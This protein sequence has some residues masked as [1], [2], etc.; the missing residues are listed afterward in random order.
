[1]VVILSLM[2][3]FAIHAQETK[4]AQKSESESQI[5][6]NAQATLLP[7]S[8][9]GLQT[10]SD[11]KEFQKDNLRELAPEME[12]IFREYRVISA[13]SRDYGSVK[14]EVFQTQNQFAAFGL[15]SFVAGATKNQPGMQPFGPESARVTSGIVFWKG[16]VFVRLRDTTL[17]S[18]SESFGPRRSWPSGEKL[19]RAISESIVTPNASVKYPPLLE[20]LPTASKI[21][22]TEQYFLGPE[23]LNADIKHGR[24]MFDFIGE[25]EAVTADYQQSGASVAQGNPTPDQAVADSQR[26]PNS[27]T[28]PDNLPLTLVIVECHTPEFATDELARVTGSVSSLPENEQ[29]QI[30]FKRTGNYIIAGVNVRDREFA[31]G[32]INSIQYP[33][34]VKWLRNPLW[35]TNDPFRTQKA[36]QMLL[37]TFGL[38]GLI[39]LTVI[40][41]GSIFGAT[42]FL[43]RRKQ[44]REIFSDAGGMLRLDIEPFVLALPPKRDK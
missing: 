22:G 44:Q 3:P 23:S 16:N 28:S 42:V 17:K 24:E 27:Q 25:T 26:G 39:I 29:Q 15:F 18:S 7:T 34:T 40:L 8:L 1:M 12:A 41:G 10:S 33:Y 9:G 35:P 6:L 13:A 19:A 5:A 21:Q 31:E 30:I 20:S 32:L 2:L 4:A 43:K 11:L 14:A 38:L 37:S 36:A